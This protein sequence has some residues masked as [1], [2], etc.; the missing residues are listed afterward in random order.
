MARSKAKNGLCVQNV[1]VSVLSL[2]LGSGNESISG[3]KGF[4]V[5]AATSNLLK[6]GQT[7]SGASTRSHDH[8]LVPPRESCA[9]L[10]PSERGGLLCAPA[11]P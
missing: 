8:G 11:E 4:D 3:H 6:G 7:M 10:H 5:V 9:L 1:V 2:H